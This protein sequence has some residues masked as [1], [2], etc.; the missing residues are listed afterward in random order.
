M[1]KAKELGFVR[2]AKAYQVC[3]VSEESRACIFE[4]QEA[5][6]KAGIK[7]DELYLKGNETLIKCKASN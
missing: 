6:V 7:G 1:K 5:H 2:L 4:S 3:S